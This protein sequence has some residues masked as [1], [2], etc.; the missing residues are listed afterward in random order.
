MKFAKLAAAT[1]A[2]ALAASGFAACGGSGSKNSADSKTQAWADSVCT[3]GAGLK[4]AAADLAD[5]LKSPN[6]SDIS[7]YKSKVAAKYSSLK[8]AVDS[9]DKVWSGATTINADTASAQFHLRMEQQSVYSAWALVEAAATKLNKATSLSSAAS[10]GADL[11]TAVS[12]S[13][14]ATADLIKAYQ[15]MGKWTNT[16]VKNAF[17]NSATCKALFAAK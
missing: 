9:V 3:A 10:A 17:N 1:A 12:Q 16:Q 7:A 14:A 11:A 5:A 13:I 6:L 15:A 4:T 8:G 2:I